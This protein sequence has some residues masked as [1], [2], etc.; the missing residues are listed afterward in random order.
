MA[1]TTTTTTALTTAGTMPLLPFHIISKPEQRHGKTTFMSLPL[2][3]RLEIYTDLLQLS[4]PPNSGEESPPYRSSTPPLST[5]SPKP[6]IHISILYAS[7][8]IYVEAL[9]LLYSLNT[10]TAHPTL[11]TAQP[12]LYPSQHTKPS[13]ATPTLP[14]PASTPPQERPFTPPS[15]SGHVITIPLSPFVSAPLNQPTIP[16]C[17]IPLIR[18]WRL[19]VKLDSPPPWSEELIGE[20]FTGARELTLDIWQSSFWGG[21]GVRTLKGFEGVRGVRKAKVRGM[22]G[23]FEGYRSWLEG[24]M[25]RPVGEGEGEVYEGKDEEEGRRLR[26]WS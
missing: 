11:L 3:L 2:E 8:Q 9:P 5:F 24:Q 18:K 20:C 16:T 19:R 10:F 15:Q 25:G 22:L 6:K 13:L 14:T 23:G 7:R 4:L 26:G 1:T 17:Y 12:S 21:V